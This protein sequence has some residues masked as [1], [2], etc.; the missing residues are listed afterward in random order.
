MF[1]S[2]H[3]NYPGFPAYSRPVEL[4][5]PSIVWALLFLRFGLLPTILLHAS[6]DLSLFSIPLFLVDAPGARV[7]QGLVILAASIPLVVV[8][9]RRLK[10][11][12]WGELPDRLRNAGWQPAHPAVEAQ[13]QAPVDRAAGPVATRFHDA[14][15]L[16]GIA[17]VVAWLAFAP[18]RADVAPLTLD[19]VDAIAAADAALA[20][21]GV[22]LG[23]QW[24]RFAVVRLATDVPQQWQAHKFVWR[25]VGAKA[26]RALVGGP[27]APPVWEVRYATFGGDVVAR[28][29]EWR[30]TVANDRSIRTIV[31]ALPEALPGAHLSRQAALAIASRELAVRFGVDTAA[32]QEVG[33]DELQ[34]PARTDWSFVFGNPQVDVGKGGEARYAVAIGGDQVT[35]AGRFVHLPETWLR[36][37]RERDNRLQIVALAGVGIFMAAGLAALI[38]G[39]RNWVRHRVDARGLR[40]VMGITFALVALG[41]LNGWPAVAMQ[42]ST[43][44]PIASQ[45]TV[46]LLAG[47]ASAL[48]I[49]LLAGLCAGVGAFGARETPPRARVGRWPATLAAIAGGAVVVGL[50]SAL[51][52]LGIRDTPLW[53]AAA[54]ASLHSPWVGAML[55][56]LDFI[57]LASAELFV[58]YAVSLLTRG[59]TRRVWLAVAVV[60]ALECATALAQGR[61]NPA[62]A[63][64]T[65]LIAG[66]VASGVLLLLLRYDLRM[67]PAFAATVALLHGATTAAQSGSLAPFALSAVATVVV[68]WL[69]TRWLWREAGAAPVPTPG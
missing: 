61:A 50:Q 42:L 25:E 68:A 15:P 34:R 13:S 30:V 24:Q 26:Y 54:W 43:T 20:A 2:A 16:L 38:V 67:V 66:A 10:A 39:I 41:A 48:A 18:F 3:A 45:L 23:P 6:F 40:W 21:R 46:R 12:A 28:A 60:V 19:R 1:G 14:L 11:G 62:A 31:H 17:G 63:L 36:A 69:M 37:E 59:F 47:A 58:V 33:A 64:F 53:P 52:A 35:A 7:Q 32:L 9:L 27:L 44:D 57:M 51:G 56:G 65:G 49:A 5:L 29:E 55:S 22:T 8:L 4:L